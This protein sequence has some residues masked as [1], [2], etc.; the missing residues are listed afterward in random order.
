M[1]KDKQLHN[2]HACWYG[3]NL[4]RQADGSH[5]EAL[6]GCPQ[7]VGHKDVIKVGR[8]RVASKHAIYVDALYC[9]FTL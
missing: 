6:A 5:R 4:S 9:Q 8:P 1:K 7:G 2:R 3:W